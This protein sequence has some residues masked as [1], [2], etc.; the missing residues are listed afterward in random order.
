MAEGATRPPAFVLMPFE[1]EFDRIFERL[2][3]PTLAEVGYEVQRADTDLSQRN[4]MRKIIE[5]I[6]NADLIVAE[7]TGNNPNVFYELGVA[8]G[9]QKPVI[10]ISQDVE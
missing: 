2:I 5:G 10:M 3:Q 8:H 9:L 7:L 6:A 4:I 1:P